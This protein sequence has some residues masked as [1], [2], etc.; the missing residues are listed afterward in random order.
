MLELN[1]I[2]QGDCL[3]LMKEI[4]DKS[5]DLII[6]D[7]PYNTLGLEWDKS[8]VD[9]NK[10]AKE[11]FRVLKEEGSLYIFCQM[12]IGFK[13]YNSFSKYLEFRQDLI[14]SKNRGI[15][16][17]KV[18]YMR[19]HENILFFNKRQ[20]YSILI[21]YLN[22]YRNKKNLTLNQINKHF[23]MATNGG[24]CAS[25]WMGN[26][27]RNTLPTEE[28]YKE[29]KRL[30]GL[31]NK[32][33]DWFYD[34]RKESHTFNF[35]DIKETGKSYY[36]TRRDNPTIYGKKSG[37]GH[38]IQI[39]EGYR[40]PKSVLQFNVIQSGKEYVGHPTQKPLELIRHLIKASSNKGDFILDCFMGSGTT[41]VACQELERDFIGI[42][43]EQKYIYLANKR[44]EQKSLSSQKGNSKSLGGKDD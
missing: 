2:H 42:E 39:N 22:K 31:D 8:K 40:H 15:S 18:A 36:K 44:L 10:L 23:G 30:L 37:M 26:K 19:T 4:E 12:P 29:L 43:K 21:D 25:Q 5:I 11:L 28:Q 35:D 38:H 16:L 9:F 27:E 1:K 7:P 6:T 17:V 34:K 20:D 24:G 32:L 33:D 3:E 13:I 14:W 41:A